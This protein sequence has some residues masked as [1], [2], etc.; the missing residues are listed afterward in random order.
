MRKIMSLFA[1]LALVLALGGCGGGK[2]VPRRKT[3][4]SEER[5]FVQ[6][7]EGDIIAIF[8]TSLGEIRAVLYPDAAPMA[9]NNF[10]GLARTG[11]YDGTVIWR[12][13]Y[14]FVVQG[15]D[16][17][18][19]GSGGGTIWSNNPY[20]LEASDSLRHYAGALCAAFSAQGGTGQFYF[21]QALPD[22]VDKTLQS[23]LTEAGYP[24]EQVAA[25]KA[26]GGLPYLDN[27]DTV[28][29]QVYQGMEVVDAIACADTVKTEDGTDTFRPAEDIVISHI[30]VTTYQAGE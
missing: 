19:T 3:V 9:V 18:G 8:E 26:A 11:Y 1:A 20:P 22:S 13:E 12:A 16:A 24:E 5:Q 2:S 10:A 6:P 29:G 28:F 7:A 23:Q 14:G 25:Y 21:V 15:G 4:N 30:T 27:T 17:D